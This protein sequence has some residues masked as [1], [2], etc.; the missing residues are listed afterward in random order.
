M[1]VFWL[2]LGCFKGHFSKTK[3]LGIGKTPPPFGKKSQKMFVVCFL[4]V[5]LFVSSEEEEEGADESY[6]VSPGTCLEAI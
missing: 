6:V 4:V 3:V 2:I 1:G 5:C